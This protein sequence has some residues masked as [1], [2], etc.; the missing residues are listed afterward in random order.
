M[1]KLSRRTREAEAMRREE[2][3]PMTRADFDR[4]VIRTRQ[5][6]IAYYTD[7]KRQRR[8]SSK[9]FRARGIDVLRGQDDGYDGRS[10]PRCYRSGDGTK[11]RPVLARSRYAASCKNPAELRRSFQW[12]LLLAFDK[13]SRWDMYSG[14]AI[15]R[16]CGFARRFCQSRL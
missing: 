2:P 13:F 9:D 14:F 11:S 6:M 5:R 3:K 15:S 10:R 4:R 16:A 12:I 1:Q 7:I 8:P